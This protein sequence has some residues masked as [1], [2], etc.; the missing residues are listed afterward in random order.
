MGIYESRPHK[1]RGRVKASFF[2]TPQRRV[3]T[4]HPRPTALS[5]RW[6]LERSELWGEAELTESPIER[7]ATAKLE[8]WAL[9]RI[10]PPDFRGP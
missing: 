8:G 9:R 4:Q 2:P 1:T 5:A 3:R 10:L 7:R 6:T